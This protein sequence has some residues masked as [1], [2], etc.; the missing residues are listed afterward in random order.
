MKMQL[1]KV[2]K[3][4]RRLYDGGHKLAPFTQTSVNF[5]KFAEH[6]FARLRRITFKSVGDFINFKT[7][8]SVMSTDFPLTGPYEKLKKPLKG[9]IIDL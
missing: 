2:G 9:S 1:L 4:Y 6:I 7:L 3:F 8:F 5:R